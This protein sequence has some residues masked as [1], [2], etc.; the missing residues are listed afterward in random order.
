VGDLVTLD[1]I[2]NT[3]DPYT[4]QAYRT[5][6]QGVSKAIDGR[7][8]ELNDTIGNLP[9]FVESG[10][11][12]FEVLDENKRALGALVKNTGVVFGALTERE[13]QLRRLIENSDTVF[14]AIQSEREDWAEVWNIFPTFLRSRA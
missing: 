11:D 14:T 3:L 4:R 12:L 1:E 10:A 7:G 5:W 2:L 13:Q 9:E 8:D 6:Q